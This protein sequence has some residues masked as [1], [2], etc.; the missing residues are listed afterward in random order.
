MP[1]DTDEFFHARWQVK[2]VE[3]HPSVSGA[4][5]PGAHG[6]TRLEDGR[7]FWLPM[8]TNGYQWLPMVTNG[9]QW[10]P[11]PT[12]DLPR[13]RKG[14]CECIRT[15]PGEFCGSWLPICFEATMDDH[16]QPC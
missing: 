12:V 16:G 4:Y 9:Y 6:M 13:A 2:L 3:K 1:V 15:L 14:P 7:F 10:L 11:I 5:A 8:V